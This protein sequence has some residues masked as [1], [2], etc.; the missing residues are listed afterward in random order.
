MGCCPFLKEPR[1]HLGT[2][3]GVGSYE[4]MTPMSYETYYPETPFHAGSSQWS[5]SPMPNWGE[6]TILSGP[7]R[8]AI[9]GL[10]AINFGRSYGPQY[11]GVNGFGADTPAVAPSPDSQKPSAALQF[12]LT[13][14]AV[15]AVALFLATRDS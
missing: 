5:Q 13:V 10:G 1:T 3:A 11:V 7:R 15:G 9:R 4:G 12:G 8:L 14:A 2:V 6:N